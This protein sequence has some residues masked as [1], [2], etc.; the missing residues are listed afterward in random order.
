[1]MEVMH[2][3]RTIRIAH[4]TGLLEMWL[5]NLTLNSTSPTDNRKIFRISYTLMILQGTHV[6]FQ[7]H[8]SELMAWHLHI[9]V[10]H[11]LM[12]A[13]RP[14]PWVLL[15]KTSK[16]QLLPKIHSALPS[17][18][19]LLK[20]NHTLMRSTCIPSN[21]PHYTLPC[22]TCILHTPYRDNIPS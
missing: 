10:I 14:Y 5:E 20:P 9:L 8:P 18:L 19:P 15:T 21:S 16:K 2:T 1:M 3:T 22:P 4:I 13:D 11:T 7:G 17:K 6:P 12:R